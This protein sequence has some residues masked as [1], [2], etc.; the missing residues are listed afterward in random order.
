MT[1][2]LTILCAA[3]LVALACLAANAQTIAIVHAKAWTMTAPTPLENATV[4]IK[5]GKIASVA[6][7]DPPPGGARVI[8]AK[9]RAVTPGLIH[10]ATHLGLLEV[11]S[12]TDTVDSGTKASSLGADFDVQYAL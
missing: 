6:A 7:G 4:V 12:A 11:S 2:R 3:P 9:G 1:R 8:D 10:P 5:E